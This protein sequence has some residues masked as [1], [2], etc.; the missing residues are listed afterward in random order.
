MHE[1]K[2]FAKF[3]F[4]LVGDIK[5][6]LGKHRRLMGARQGVIS[7]G[8]YDIL[9]VATKDFNGPFNGTVRQ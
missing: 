3:E 5:S 6:W 1:L 9:A 2:S 8:S 7:M 4:V